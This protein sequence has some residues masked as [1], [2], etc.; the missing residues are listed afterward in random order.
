MNLRKLSDNE[1]SSLILSSANE[2]VESMKEIMFKDEYKDYY[3]LL[4][5]LSEEWSQRPSVEGAKQDGY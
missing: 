5:A 1:L 4:N 3:G 2:M